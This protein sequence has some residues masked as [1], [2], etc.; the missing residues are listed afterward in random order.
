MLNG[1]QSVTFC[2]AF[3]PFRWCLNRVK[4]RSK[5]SCIVILKKTFLHHHVALCKHPVIGQA[6]VGSPETC[7]AQTHL[8]VHMHIHAWSTCS[9]NR[10]LCI[11]WSCKCPCRSDVSVHV[12]LSFVHCTF[13]PPFV[14]KSSCSLNTGGGC[15][16]HRLPTLEH[17]RT[18][19]ENSSLLKWDLWA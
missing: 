13:I 10:Y 6:Q 5:P 1:K 3:R 19:D 15:D 4:Q 11:A 9:C 17:K 16:K 7:R 8:F 12:K 18:L 14:V 2:L